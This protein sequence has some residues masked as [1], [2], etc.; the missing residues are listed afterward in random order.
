[1]HQKGSRELT[2]EELEFKELFE[3]TSEEKES[4]AGN[5]PLPLAARMRP[6]TLSE[7][8]GH[9]QILGEGAL[10]PRLVN[11]NRFGSIL[12]SGPPGCGK[13]SLAEAIAAQT[14]SRMIRV[15]AVH[16]SS[17]QGY[18]VALVAETVAKTGIVPGSASVDLT[19]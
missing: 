2:M 3:G 18:S 19:V 11:S 15:N 6:R 1:M 13:T 9:E 14:G 5:T 17:F 7:M 12:L 8:V 16:Q 10:L 4:P